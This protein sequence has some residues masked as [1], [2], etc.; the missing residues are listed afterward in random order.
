[1]YP[2]RFLARPPIVK[3]NMKEPLAELEAELGVPVSEIE[4]VVTMF[5]LIPAGD[6]DEG[7]CRRLEVAFE[8]RLAKPHDG[9]ALATK[10]IQPGPPEKA[11]IAGKSYFRPN[12][13]GL[14]RAY[15]K[16][17]Y[18]IDDRTFLCGDEA[19]IKAILRAARPRLL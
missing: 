3:V 5:I 14:T 17:V 1:M 4:Q 15:Q 6:A 11:E 9:S 13:K 12:S 19:A 18:I 7:R 8:I 10:V 2:S 16:A